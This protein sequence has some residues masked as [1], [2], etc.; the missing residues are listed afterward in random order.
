MFNEIKF[1]HTNTLSRM[2]RSFEKELCG[3]FTIVVN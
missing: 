1:G 2:T 3:T